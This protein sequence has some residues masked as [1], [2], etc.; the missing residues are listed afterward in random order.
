MLFLLNPADIG[1]S[2][3]SVLQF[4]QSELWFNG[5][6]SLYLHKVSWPELN[7][8]DNFSA[9]R[10]KE[11]IGNSKVSLVNNINRSSR[12]NVFCRKSFLEISEN[13]K[14]NT[15]ARVSFL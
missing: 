3:I 2:S 1:K 6:K 13:A 14:E 12:T 7:V 4:T 5:P 15:C 8:G 10:E 9:Y 11:L